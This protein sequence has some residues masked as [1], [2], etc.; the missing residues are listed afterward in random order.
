MSGNVSEWEDACD[1]AGAN[2]VTRGGSYLAADNATT[3]A[4]DSIVTKARMAHDIDTGF[5]CCQY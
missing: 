2:C 5:R 3:L 1:A 4:C